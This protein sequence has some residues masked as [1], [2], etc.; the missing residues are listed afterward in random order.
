MNMPTQSKAHTKN[1]REDETLGA[2][3]GQQRVHEFKP[4]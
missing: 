1:A 2:S 4:N 3:K